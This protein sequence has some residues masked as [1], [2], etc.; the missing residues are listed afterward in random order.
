MT[1]SKPF[2]N[3]SFIVRVGV[4]NTGPGVNCLTPRQ[5]SVG[6][7]PGR[8]ARLGAPP[9]ANTLYQHPMTALGAFL[10]NALRRTLSRIQTVL[11]CFQDSHRTSN[12]FP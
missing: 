10:A 8:A 6:H 2:F 9:T 5:A 7:P 3:L 12:I 4:E 11:C 1:C